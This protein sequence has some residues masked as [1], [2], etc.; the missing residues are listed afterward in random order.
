[1]TQAVSHSV[2]FE[3]CVFMFIYIETFLL[4][5][6]NRKNKQLSTKTTVLMTVRLFV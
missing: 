1:M 5:K 3:I 4:A 2:S 6:R